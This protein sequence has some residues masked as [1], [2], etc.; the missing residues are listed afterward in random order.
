M[1]SATLVYWALV[2][3]EQLRPTAALIPL[4]QNNGDLDAPPTTNNSGLLS[5]NQHPS[6]SLFFPAATVSS[7]GAK[8]QQCCPSILPFPIR[9]EQRASSGGA[10]QQNHGSGGLDS[11]FGLFFLLAATGKWC[12]GR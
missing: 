10:M 8:N 1:G 11:F 3:S 9:C 4:R 2:L 5:G 7:D 6:P 12:A